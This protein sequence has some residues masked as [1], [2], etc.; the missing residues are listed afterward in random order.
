M[1]TTLTECATC[2]RTHDPWPGAPPLDR[3]PGRPRPDVP[4]LPAPRT[5][6]ALM[7]VI[8][9]PQHHLCELVHK[10]HRFGDGCDDWH[11]GQAVEVAD[12]EF[13]AATGTSDGSTEVFFPD[14]MA[15][16]A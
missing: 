10:P 15:L 9:T 11:K 12:L 16:T 5:G 1:T 3:P 2:H 13:Y 6:R 4:G 7:T 14:V 8:A